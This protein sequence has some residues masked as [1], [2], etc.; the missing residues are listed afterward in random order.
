MGV[1]K[2]AWEGGGVSGC[3]IISEKKMRVWNRNGM[4]L[5]VE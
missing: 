2:R 1:G 5:R 4:E 3:G